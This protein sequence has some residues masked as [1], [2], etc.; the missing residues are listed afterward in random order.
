MAHLLR[1]TRKER[2]GTEDLAFQTLSVLERGVAV[3]FFV[4]EN[5]SGKST[6]LEAMAAAA[7]LP[8]LGADQVGFDDTLAGQRALGSSLR[9][10]WTRRSRQGFFLRAEDSRPRIRR[11]DVALRRRASLRPTRQ[12]A[13]STLRPRRWT[14]TMVRVRRCSTPLVMTT[15]H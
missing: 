1:V 15:S 6:L 2:G 7:E 8:S 4:G 5:G 9:L 3:T 12:S 13:T 11:S 14:S 10:S